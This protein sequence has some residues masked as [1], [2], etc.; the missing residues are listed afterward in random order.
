MLEI[1]LQDKELS[2]QNTMLRCGCGEL[3]VS[4]VIT[5]IVWSIINMVELN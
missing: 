2:V 3:T 5:L 1:Y 4:S